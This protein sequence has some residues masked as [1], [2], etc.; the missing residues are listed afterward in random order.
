VIR[1]GNPVIGKANPLRRHRDAENSQL[2]PGLNWGIPG[3]ELCK[4]FRILDRVRGGG[5]LLD[6]GWPTFSVVHSKLHEEVG[7][8]SIA[9]GVLGT[10]LFCVFWGGKQRVG[11]SD[12]QLHS[13]WLAE[14]IAAV[15]APAPKFRRFCQFPLDGIIVHVF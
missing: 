6:G 3:D 9:N 7:T 5:V 10:R 8:N 12:P 15:A 4:P 11:G 13:S 14:T 2:K 1:I